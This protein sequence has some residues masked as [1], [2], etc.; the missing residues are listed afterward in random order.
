MKPDE[1]SQ[2]CVDGV[3]NMLNASLEKDRPAFNSLFDKYVPCNAK[4]ADE[5]LIIVKEN[6]LND[7]FPYLMGTLGIINAVVNYFFKDRIAIQY[8]D[9]TKKIVK[10][11]RYNP[12]TKTTQ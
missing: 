9:K 12:D 11:C 4:I 1:L 7:D 2:K 8:D 6:T 3:I 5:T 10:F